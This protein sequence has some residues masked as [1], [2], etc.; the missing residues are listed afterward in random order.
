MMKAREPL[1][2]YFAAAP[3]VFLLLLLLTA[4]SSKAEESGAAQL[5]DEISDRVPVITVAPAYPENARRDRIEGEVQLCYQVDKNG[6]PYRVAV[7]RS[8]HRV[9]ERPSMRAIKA[10]TYVP[11][12]QG[13][14]SSGIKTCRTFRFQLEPVDA[15]AA[16]ANFAARSVFDINIAMVIGPTPPGTGVIAAATSSASS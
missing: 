5:I 9:F 1:I 13:E 2:N 4:T 6:R 10:S 8:T 3:L 12:K 14:K 15:P 7:R 16:K 11:L